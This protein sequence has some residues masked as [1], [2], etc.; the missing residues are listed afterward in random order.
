MEQNNN[1]QERPSKLRNFLETAQLELNL[2]LEQLE[3][4]ITELNPIIAIPNQRRSALH[5]T[6]YQYQYSLK[7]VDQRPEPTFDEEVNQT[8]GKIRSSE[9]TLGLRLLLQE[10]ERKLK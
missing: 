2:I 10:V 6:L 9:T 5:N 7:Q 4:Q 1:N 8:L 3:P